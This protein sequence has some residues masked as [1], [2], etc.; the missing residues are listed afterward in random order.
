MD[1]HK[2]RIDFKVRLT[3]S[4]LFDYHT[5]MTA[6]GLCATFPGLEYEQPSPSEIRIFGDLNDYW[7]DEFHRAVFGLGE[8]YYKK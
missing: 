8:A 5:T 1:E 7:Y 6:R 2:N 4:H 3:G